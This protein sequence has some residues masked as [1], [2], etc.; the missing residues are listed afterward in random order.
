MLSEAVIANKA[1][2]GAAV[3]AALFI[4]E[5]IAASAP[6]S[7]NS[8]RLLKNGALWILLTILSPMI[9]LPL[10]MIAAE[11]PLWAR[12]S[13]WL[14]AVTLAA[15]I[16]FLDLWAYGIHRAYHEVRPMWRFHRVHHLDEHLDTTSAVRF[17]PGEVALSA[18]LRM[19]PICLLAIPFN[20]VLVFETALLA[21]TFFHH[22]NTRLPKA[23]EQAMS[24]VVVTPSIHWV[25][26]HA[27]RADTNS[28]YAAIFS[29]WDRVF[30][31]RSATRRTPDMKIGLE[32]V[33]DKSLP[34]LLLAPFQAAEK[35]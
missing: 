1:W 27:V 35:Q 25:H 10:T 34:G 23:L 8:G 18:A 15:D 26:H 30:D 31:T 22:S 20:H 3:F 33:A 19:I 14:S 24:Y 12:P 7:G 13:D 16:V 6:W 17:H 29:L 9:V 5:R 28:S 4:L 32:N 21:A 11:H 2:I